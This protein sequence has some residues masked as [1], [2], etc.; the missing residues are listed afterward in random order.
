MEEP[1]ENLL[2]LSQL[3]KLGLSD[4]ELVVMEADMQSIMALMD[5][6]K[7]ID[8][9]EIPQPTPIDICSLRE[10]VSQP[11]L[12]RELLLSES[13]GKP[14]TFFTIPQVVG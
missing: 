4:E 9:N 11:C 7:S 3:A 14:G 6:V 13:P 10:D 5:T 8:I 1:M 12:D 2:W